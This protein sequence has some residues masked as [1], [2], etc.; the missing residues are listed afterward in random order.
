M[1]DVN[2]YKYLGATLDSELTKFA[3]EINRKFTNRIFKFANLRYMMDEHTAITIYKQTI[4]PFADYCSFILDS[5]NKKTT[6][7]RIQILQN[8][9]LRI[10]LRCKM[11]DETVDGL[12]FRC[13]RRVSRKPVEISQTAEAAW[14]TLCW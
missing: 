11:R 8:Q 13:K 5:A 9:A 3:D 7:S 12:H 6:I 4:L 2:S 14:S 10:C 1:L